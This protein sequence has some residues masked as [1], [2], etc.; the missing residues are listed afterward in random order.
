M[1]DIEHAEQAEDHGKPERE[2]RQRGDAVE[3]LI[4]W[5]TISGS[6]CDVS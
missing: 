6:I 3:T 2:H 1:R 5:V 4:A